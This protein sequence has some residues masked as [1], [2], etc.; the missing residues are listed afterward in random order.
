MDKYNTWKTNENSDDEDDTHPNIDMPSLFSWR[1]QL[2]LERM[3]EHEKKKKKL[4]IE[5]TNNKNQFEYVQKAFKKCGNNEMKQRRLYADLREIQ[6]KKGELDAKYEKLLLEEKE[7]PWNEDVMS[8]PGS[9][10]NK[11]NE[12]LNTMY[13]GLPVEEKENRM[14]DFLKDN[15]KLIIQFGMLRKFEDSKKFLLENDQLVREATANYLIVWCLDLELK[16]KSRLIKHVAQ[17]SICMQFILDMAKHLDTKPRACISPFFER[18]QLVD[19]KYKRQF[20]I[21]V[22]SFKELLKKRVTVKIEDVLE[23]TGRK[24]RKGPG[25][26]DPNEVF[27]TLTEP[28]QKCFLVRDLELLRDTLNEMPEYEARYHLDRCIASGLWVPDASKKPSS[29]SLLT[30]CFEV[31]YKWFDKFWRFITRD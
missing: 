24:Y 16:K 19:G 25:G 9:E 5:R 4:E 22:E 1:R 10:K 30:K 23:K 6:M 14:R 29:T 8:K 13:D 15:K 28:L 20:D 21:E 7:A 17:Q 18:I 2:R 31:F 3:Q 26:L 11:I 12:P 27:E